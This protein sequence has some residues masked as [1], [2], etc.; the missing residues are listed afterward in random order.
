MMQEG[1]RSTS[2]GIGVPGWKYGYSDSVQLPIYI[3]A[4]W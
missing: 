4:G 1:H 3:P 2:A